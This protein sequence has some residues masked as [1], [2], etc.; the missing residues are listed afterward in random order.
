MVGERWFI[1]RVRGTGAEVALKNPLSGTVLGAGW[2]WRG[3]ATGRL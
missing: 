2:I 3:E 1:Q